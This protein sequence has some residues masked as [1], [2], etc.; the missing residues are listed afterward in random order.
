MIK[1]WGLKEWVDSARNDI[2]CTSYID[3]Q[4]NGEEVC[5]NEMNST[6]LTQLSAMRRLCHTI[7]FHSPSA[8]LLYL[9]VMLLGHS[10]SNTADR[11]MRVTVVLNKFGPNL[12]E[13][14]PRCVRQSLY[15]SCCHCSATVHLLKRTPLPCVVS[16]YCMM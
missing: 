7:S 16:C 13:R 4:D 9:Q 15:I 10:D 12:N 5:L 8:P 14:M 11:N 2:I 1:S 6:L 3:N